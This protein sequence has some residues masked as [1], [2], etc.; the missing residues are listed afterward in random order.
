[1]DFERG[2][3]I[4]I[5]QEGEKQQAKTVEGKFTDNSQRKKRTTLQNVGRQIRSV[6]TRRRGK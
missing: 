3:S 1:M 2:P 4:E 5:L 6:F